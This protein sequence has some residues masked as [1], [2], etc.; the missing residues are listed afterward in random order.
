MSRCGCPEETVQQSIHSPGVVV[1][2]EPVVFALVLVTSADSADELS[3]KIFQKTKLKEKRQSF[4]RSTHCTFEEMYDLVI[5]P[6]MSAPGSLEYKGYLWATTGE[7]RSIVAERNMARDKAP[8]LTPAPVGAFCVIDDGEDNY[9]AHARVGYA[10][11]LPQFWNL[12][13]S[14]RARGD[15]LITLQRRGKLCG[16]ASPPFREQP[17]IWRLLAGY[18]RAFMTNVVDRR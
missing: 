4:C 16:A 10:N 12:H 13:Q 18:F 11:P 7:I 14:N 9:R 6:R 2:E 8:H 1:N 5:K 17:R 15:L 3:I